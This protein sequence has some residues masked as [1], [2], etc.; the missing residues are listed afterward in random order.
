[1]NHSDAKRK[2]NESATDYKYRICKDRDILGLDTWKQVAE[3]LNKEFESDWSDSTYRKWFTNFHAGIEYAKSNVNDDEYIQEL[4]DKTIEF[5]KQKFQYQDQKREY[6]NLIRQQAR[7]EH[8]KDEI[9]KS[10]DKLKVCKPLVFNKKSPTLSNVKANTLWS[11]WHFG[12][13][14]K[15]SLNAYNPQIFKERLKRLV[16]ETVYY[17]EKH[18]VSE[19]TIGLLGDFLNGAIHVSTRVQSS[20]NV[21]RQVQVVSESICEAVVEISKYVDKIKI[22]NIIGNHARLVPE[23]TQSVFKE[24][25]E[26]LIPWY[27]ESRLSQFDNIEIR[28]DEDGYYVDEINGEKVIYVHGDLDHISS[29]AKTLPQMLGIVPKYIFCG[30]IHHDTVK[31]VGRT[32][33]ISNGSLVGIDDYAISKRFYAEP[34]QKMHIFRDNR[35]EY[36]IPIELK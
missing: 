14:F 8:L 36:Y 5:K 20:E 19:L 17:I 26:K 29:V 12:S 27:L 6:E 24:N 35:I 7:F 34:M 15:N 13:D 21:I 1:M 4:N 28:S 30:H 33:V 18:N 2:L 11:D 3:L 22:I 25:L 31:E 10:I 16:E 9:V 32:K 23:K